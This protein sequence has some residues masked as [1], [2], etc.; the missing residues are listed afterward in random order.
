MRPSAAGARV[1][2]TDI[3]R[4]ADI[5]GAQ[6][7]RADVRGRVL[8]GPGQMTARAPPVAGRCA[9][10]LDFHGTLSGETLRSTARQSVCRRA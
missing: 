10:Q 6:V 2:A 5:A 1:A 9:T 7:V 8:G 4:G 3:A